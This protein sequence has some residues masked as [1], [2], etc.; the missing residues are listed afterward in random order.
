MSVLSI[1][2][3][4]GAI[5]GTLLLI[6]I[7]ARYRCRKNVP[8][9]L[10]LLAFSVRLGTVPAWTPEVVAGAPWVLFGAGPLPLL[11]GPLIWWYV[12]ALAHDFE[13]P[14]RRFYLHMLPW[15]LETAALAAFLLSRSPSEYREVV[16]AVFDTPLPWW[17]T[18]RHITKIIHGG[19]YA[20]AAARIVFGREG[21]SLFGPDATRRWAQA[22]V[23][24]PLL[25]LGAFGL[26]AA[27]PVVTA[28]A[29]GGQFPL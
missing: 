18:V 16:R 4:L 10:F 13:R 23:V 27:Q 21:R 14:P 8:F 11:F 24:A 25:S 19:I 20:I 15:V 7:A 22:V 9:A 12:R 2:A 26:A 17:M 1:V 5:Q 6:L 29:L 3:A 28:P